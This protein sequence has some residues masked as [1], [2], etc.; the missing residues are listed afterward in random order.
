MTN[1]ATTDHLLTRNGDAPPC[2]VTVGILN[3]YEV[4]VRGVAAML[5]PYDDRV[6]VVHLA[7]DNEATSSSD[8]SAD[9]EVS[10][11]VALFDSFAGRRHSLS[12]AAEMVATGRATSR[13]PV[14]VGCRTGVR[15]RGATDRRLRS[16]AQD[17]IGRCAGRC[18]RTRGVG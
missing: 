2:A 5:A 15:P 3:D 17:P 16:R 11:D 4:V 18:H 6:R 1:H 10:A 7:T 13:D 12:R 14:H 8:M 9:S